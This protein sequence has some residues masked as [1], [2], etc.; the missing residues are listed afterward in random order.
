MNALP[1]M[2][3]LMLLSGT[4]DLS[5]EFSKGNLTLFKSGSLVIKAHIL[6]TYCP[7]LLKYQAPYSV[8]PIWG[9]FPRSHTCAPKTLP[10]DIC[11]T[12]GPLWVEPLFLGRA[13]YVEQ[14]CLFSQIPLPGGSGPC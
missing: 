4:T 9:N 14:G 8:C 1:T 3:Y 13:A 12:S 10:S 2:C 6:L 5:F 7:L 11:K